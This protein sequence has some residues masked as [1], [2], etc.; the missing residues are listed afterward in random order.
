M[1]EK[2][3]LIVAGLCAV[4]LLL[5]GEGDEGSRIVRADADQ[6]VIGPIGESLDASAD[7]SNWLRVSAGEGSDLPAVAGKVSPQGRDLLFKPAF[8]LSPRIEYSIRFKHDELGEFSG[9]FRVSGAAVPP[10]AEVVAI[11]PSSGRL[12]QNLLKFYVHFSQPMSKGE[13]YDHIRLLDAEGRVVQ[14]PFLELAEEL[15]DVDG[16]RL[17]VFLDPGRVKRG[18]RPHQEVGPVLGEGAEYRLE[19]GG[20]WR[21]AALQPIGKPFAKRFQTMAPDYDCPDPKEWRLTVPGAGTR[22]G[23]VIDFGEALDSALVGRLLEVH[24]GRERAPIAG[25]GRALRDETGWE[26]VPER[27]WAAQDY[28]L[29]VGSEL[30]DLAGNSVRKPFEVTK[31]NPAKVFIGPSVSVPFAVGQ[32]VGAR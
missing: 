6:V 15:W 30:E 1:R 23:L 10:P 11:Y 28:R 5:Q 31:D 2:L 29:V 17:T 7:W 3:R 32:P 18:L 12:P 19:V 14:D 20:A 26:F 21:D 22:Q 27:P 8:P 25:V 9:R 16:K 4:P 24:E 13:A